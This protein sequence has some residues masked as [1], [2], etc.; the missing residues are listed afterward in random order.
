MVLE[1]A[2]SA[3]GLEGVTDYIALFDRNIELLT[4]ALATTTG[5]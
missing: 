2:P 5:R 4:G 1:L 3:G